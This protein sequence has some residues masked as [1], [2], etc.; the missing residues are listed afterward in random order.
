MPR[1]AI[2]LLAA[3]VLFAGGFGAGAHIP[4]LAAARVVIAPAGNF[5]LDLTFD[6]PPFVLDLT[7][8]AATDDAMNAWLDGPTNALAQSLDVAQSRFQ[9]EFSVVTDKGAG[10]ADKIMFPRLADLERYKE[11]VPMVQLPV[12]L[13]LSLEGRLPAG[14]RSVS[15]RFPAVMGIVAI[16]VNRPGQPPATLVANSGEAPPPI[17]AKRR[18]RF[19][20]SLPTPMPCRQPRRRSPNRAAG[21]WRGNISRSALNTY[22]RKGRTTSCSCW[23]CFC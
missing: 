11:S 7:P 19:P 20:S 4:S 5:T 2:R 14:A 15:F 17:P 10:R 6:V 3:A 8:P 9:R 23:G 21:W 13:A 16:T 18:R 1:F 12:M 22:C